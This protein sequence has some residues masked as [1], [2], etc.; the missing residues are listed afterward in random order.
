MANGKWKIL[1][2][3][4]KI[5]STIYFRSDWLSAYPFLKSDDIAITF[6]RGWKVSSLPNPISQDS[7]PLAYF[8][9]AEINNGSLHIGRILRFDLELV[10]KDQYQVLRQFFQMVRTHDEQQV[11]LQPIN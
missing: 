9:K 4:Q 6:P 10:S 8:H 11:V 7:A 3:I 5:A 2:P 1:R